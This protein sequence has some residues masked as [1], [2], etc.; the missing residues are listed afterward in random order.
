VKAWLLEPDAGGTRLVLAD[1]P[2]LRP[3]P[4]DLLVETRAI[5]LNRADLSLKAGH[6]QH[7]A[8]RP[9]QPIAGLEAAGVVVGMGERVTGWKPGDRVMGMPSGAYAEQVLLH[10]RLA[11][12]VP[13]AL[14]WAEAAALP[15]ALLTAHDALITEGA[16]AP[17]AAVLVQGASSGVGIGALQVARWRGASAVIG[18][19]GAAKLPELARHGMTHGVDRGGD[20]QAAIERAAPG[21]VDVIADLVGAT[22]ASLHLQ[23]AATGARWVQIGRMG[24][25]VAQ[26]DLNLVSLKRLRLIGV[27]FRSRS[28]DEFAAVAHAAWSD[29]G[30]AVAHKRFAMP[31]HATFRF[32]QVQQAHELMRENRHLGKLVLEV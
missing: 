17:G 22:A 12:P 28:V 2:A 13:G 11:L 19:A 3:G 23:V 24:G 1:V 15:V 9:P 14:G 10:H 18:V 21:G 32:S 26:I 5:G 29:L 30:A 8:T 7:V 6:Y 25:L 16:L 31:V 4:D 20:C 27:T